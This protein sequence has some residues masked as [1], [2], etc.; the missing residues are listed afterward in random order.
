M[1]THTVNTGSNLQIFITETLVQGQSTRVD[2]VEIN[3]QT[4]SLSTDL[5]RVARL[6]DEWYEDVRNPESVINALKGASEFSPDI[7]TFWQR[8]PA[9]EPMYEYYAEWESLAALEIKSF[10]YWWNKKIKGT[11]RNMIRKSQKAGVE[12][13]ECSYDD[14]FVRGMTEIFNETPV[15][16]GRRFWHYG[17]DFETI[18]R[19]FSRYLFRE[20]LIGA[21]C[22]NELA[23][24]IM[25]ANAGN[26]GIL[27]QFISKLQFRAKAINN[28]LI[29]H[30]VKVC[31]K[32]KLPYLVYGYWAESSLADFK[33]HSGFEERKLPRYYIPLTRK[34]K[35]ALKLG[36]HRGWKS[37]LPKQLK[38]QLKKF[39][40]LCHQA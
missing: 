38:I 16:Q 24:F 13:R 11:T 9:V 29:A 10:D 26:Y 5:V 19:Q 33:R 3:G 35:I 15:R 36:L 37:V 7:F 31:A 30:A 34:G 6:Q 14:E 28:A 12:V 8:L 17:K 18:K 39:R 25:L 2:C 27:A 4:Y 21:Y 40:A 20:D 32:R 23:G 1:Q 22:G